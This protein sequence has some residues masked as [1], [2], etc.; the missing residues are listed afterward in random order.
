MMGEILLFAKVNVS[1]HVNGPLTRPD[2]TMLF[3]VSVLLVYFAEFHL[4]SWLVF[5]RRDVAG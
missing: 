5:T 2:M 3:P 1:H 4:I